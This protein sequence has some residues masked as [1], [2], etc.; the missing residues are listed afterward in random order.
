MLVV[1]D[2]SA[3]GVPLAGRSEEIQKVYE[4]SREAVLIDLIYKIVRE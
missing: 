1:S 2:N 4:Y 3:T